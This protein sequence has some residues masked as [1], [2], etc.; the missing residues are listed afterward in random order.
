MRTL[1]VKSLNVV[2]VVNT[3]ED[4]WFCTLMV[5]AGW[6]LEYCATAENST[7]C[8]DNFDEFFKQRRRWGPSTFANSIVV[9][10]EQM[11]LRNNN[12]A[13]SFFFILYQTVLLISN[14]IRY[15]KLK[16]S[17]FMWLSY[18]F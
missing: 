5:E 14:V 16:L 2:I 6:K 11:K 10:K 9:I 17:F 15:V 8:P 12:D 4:R 3:G 13:I 18:E 1:T 7:Y